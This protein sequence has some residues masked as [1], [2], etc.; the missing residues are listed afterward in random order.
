MTVVLAYRN[1]RI[2]VRKRPAK[3][4]L[5]GLWEFPNFSEGTLEDILPGARVTGELPKAKHVFTHLVWNMRGVRAEVDSVP[6]GMRAVDAAGLQALPFPTAL[7][8]YRE[9]AQRE[10]CGETQN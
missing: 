10:L 8:V 6:D 7:R 3:G 5:A 4:L 9:I 2:L 1:G